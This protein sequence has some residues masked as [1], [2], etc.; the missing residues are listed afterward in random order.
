MS[1]FRRLKV[2][3][4]AAALATITSG[5]AADAIQQGPAFTLAAITTTVAF[6]IW[7]TCAG[8]LLVRLCK[9]FYATRAERTMIGNALW[10]MAILWV[11]IVVPLI[12]RLP[13]KH[14]G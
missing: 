7:V 2:I 5:I 11:P 9:W 4:Y 3:G 6:A 12:V 13:P 10:V 14:Q 1:K 8:I